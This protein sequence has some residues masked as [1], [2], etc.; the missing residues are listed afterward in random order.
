MVLAGRMKSSCCVDTTI[1]VTL[2]GLWSGV[3]STVTWLLAQKNMAQ[4]E[5]QR[6]EVGSLVAGI[7]EHH[8]LVAGALLFG[9]RAVDAA[10]DVAALFVERVQHS[11]G[12]GVELKLRAVV[13]DFRDNAARDIHQVDVG[14][15]FH[16][17]GN[18]DL[19]GGDERLA[20]N[21][22]RRIIGQKLVE[23]SVADLVGNFVGVSF[24]HRLRREKIVFGIHWFSIFF[25]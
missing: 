14:R 7:A 18:N 24:R 3:Y 25:V 10:A 16:L 1:V 19:P 11:A 20:G 5:S 13:A 9:S 17:A 23:N 12:L 22:A 8:A 2:T 21:A 15:R 4:V 6:H